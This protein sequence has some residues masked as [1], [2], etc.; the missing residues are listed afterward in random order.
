M[1]GV[2]LKPLETYILIFFNCLL[3]SPSEQLSGAHTNEIKLDHSPIVLIYDSSYK[4]YSCMYKN[5]H[6]IGVRL[7]H[8]SDF[9]PVYCMAV[10]YRNTLQG[11]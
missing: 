2:G 8:G 11:F 6:H 3:S 10:I 9:L 7:I 4:A 1:P 5:V